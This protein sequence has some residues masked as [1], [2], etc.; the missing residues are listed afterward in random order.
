M[1]GADIKGKLVRCHDALDGLT[2]CFHWASVAVLIG[3]VILVNCDVAGRALFDRPIAGVSEIMGQA[4]V[5]FA[6]LQ[7]PQAF[8]QRRF[9]RNDDLVS[10]LNKRRP[11]LGRGLI[12]SLHGLSITI[13]LPLIYYSTG[14]LVRDWTDGDFVGAIGSITVPTWPAR[15][16][17]VLGSIVL[18]LQIAFCGLLRDSGADRESGINL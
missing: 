12:L 8:R 14:Y 1:R 13:L 3:L 9:L 17:V 11:R 2:R 16:A 5:I 4:V 15:L 10:S 7:G 18:A 6:F